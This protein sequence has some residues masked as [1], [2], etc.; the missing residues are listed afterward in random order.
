MKD[1]LAEMYGGEP[2][3]ESCFYYDSVFAIGYALKWLLSSGKD[4]ENPQVLTDALRESRFIGCTGLVTIEENTKHRS[5]IAY[6]IMNLQYI[7]DQGTWS[8]ERVGKND[9][10]SIKILDLYSNIQLPD[11]TSHVPSDIRTKDSCL[12]PESEL[13]EVDCKN[14]ILLGVCLFI[15]AVSLLITIY[16]W[17]RWWTVHIS[18]LNSTVEISIYDM[19]A[20][21]MIILNSLQYNSTFI[22][23][24]DRSKESS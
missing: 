15:Y 19:I 5:P 13:E 4:Y 10:T 3:F 20:I 6:D 16:I 18:T 11:G 8:I 22:L 14:Y 21:A 9:P 17:K 24:R 2:N 23:E 12:Y 7:K 1:E